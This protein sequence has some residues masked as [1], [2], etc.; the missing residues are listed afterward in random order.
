MEKSLSILTKE[1]TKNTNFVLQSWENKSQILSNG[2]NVNLILKKNE[3][4]TKWSAKNREFHK[5]VVKRKSW[6]STNDLEKNCEF[7]QKISETI[8][9]YH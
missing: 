1:C 9:D 7:H 4:L 8:C 6:I 2:K 3:N 5:S